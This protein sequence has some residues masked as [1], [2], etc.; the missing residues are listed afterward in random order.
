VDAARGALEDVEGVV[1]L[2]AEQA[3]GDVLAVSALD[4]QCV[5]RRVG[6]GEIVAVERDVGERRSR[7]ERGEID[8][9]GTVAAADDEAAEAAEVCIFE[10]FTAADGIANGG[11]AVASGSA[12][13][14]R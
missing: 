8:G 13:V 11:D 1:A 9:V 7:I 4:L 10:T 14:D 2:A 12:V 3:N 6:V 5:G